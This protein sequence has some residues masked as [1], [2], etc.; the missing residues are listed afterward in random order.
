MESINVDVKLSY[1]AGLREVV[2]NEVKRSIGL[3]ILREGADS[4]F[5]SY[6]QDFGA[7]KALRSVARAYLTITSKKYNPGYVSR[8]KSLLAKLIIPVISGNKAS[9]RTFKLI[10]AGSSSPEVRSIARYIAETYGLFERDDAD[11]KVHLIKLGD[12]WELGAQITPRPLSL[13]QYKL[14]NMGGA[15]DP[16]IAYSLNSLCGLERAHSYLNV[17]SGSATLL[18]EAA[19]CFPHLEKLIGF[20]N[21]KNHISLAIQNIK[22]AGLIKKITLLERDLREKPDLGKFDVITSDLPFGMAISK[23]EDLE[24]LYALF[25]DYSQIALNR[26]GVIAVYTNAHEIFERCLAKSHFKVVMALKLKL[27]TAAN[28]YITPMIFVCR[29]PTQKG[30][31]GG[32]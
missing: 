11:L 27:M 14:R 18:I 28:A 31:Y 20:D 9:F 32:A 5:I 13:R 23:G 8:H 10:C 1:I 3:P 24:K 6:V 30:G 22:Q 29:I 25:V 17:F 4:V 21:Q 19:E 26:N 15:M 2:I 16:T 12:N 7:I